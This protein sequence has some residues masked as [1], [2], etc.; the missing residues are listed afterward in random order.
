MKYPIGT[1]VSIV[2]HRSSSWRFTVC[3]AV[4]HRTGRSGSH[5]MVCNGEE[6]LVLHDLEFGNLSTLTIHESLAFDAPTN[7][8]LLFHIPRNRNSQTR[9]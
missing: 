3:C 5:V 8:E 1:R 7:Q 6:V 9:G 2:Y 4:E